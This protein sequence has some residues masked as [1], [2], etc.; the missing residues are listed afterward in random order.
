MKV[1]G[2]IRNSFFTSRLVIYVLAAAFIFSLGFFIHFGQEAHVSGSWKYV[3][4][5][6]DDLAL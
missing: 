2:S 1:Q 5:D 4:S 3:M 6:G